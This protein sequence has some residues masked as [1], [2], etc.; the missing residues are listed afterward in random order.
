M[1]QHSDVVKWGNTEIPYKYSFSRRKT[2]SISVHPDLL[3]TAKAPVGTNIA[4]IRAFVRRRC[5]WIKKKWWDFEQYLPKQPARRYISGETHFYLGRQHRLKVEQGET[6][7]VKCYRGYL[8]VTAKAD[9]SPERVKLLLDEW[10]R[11]HAKFIFHER[12]LSCQQRMAREGIPLPHLQIRKLRGR[13]GS[14]SSAGR[15]TLNLSLIK[16]PIECI[17]YVILHE[18]CH[19]KERHHGLRF[20]KLMQKLMPDYDKRRTKLNKCNV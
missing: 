9:Q 19:F 15:I 14:Y 7:S 12:L 18:L 8:W 17:D 16:T 10:Y 5:A 4:I 20:W 3:V 2:L 6:D 13:W 11:S 1:E